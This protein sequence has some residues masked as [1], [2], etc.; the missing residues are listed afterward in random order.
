MGGTGVFWLVSTA[1]Q[2]FPKFEVWYNAT[3]TLSISL[4]VVDMQNMGLVEQVF[5]A[6]QTVQQLI[7]VFRVG[8]EVWAGTSEMYGGGVDLYHRVL[9][10]GAAIFPRWAHWRLTDCGTEPVNWMYARHCQFVGTYDLTTRVGTQRAR[11]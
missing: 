2:V 8:I 10:A 3:G 7:T 6:I 1:A 9:V 4:P 11:L 5:P